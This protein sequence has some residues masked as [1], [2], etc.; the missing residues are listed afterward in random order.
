MITPSFEDEYNFPG[1]KDSTILAGTRTE[2]F[3]DACEFIFAPEIS[4]ETEESFNFSLKESGF[5]M[6]NALCFLKSLSK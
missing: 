5:Y 3:P 1:Y 2:I 4:P 6:E